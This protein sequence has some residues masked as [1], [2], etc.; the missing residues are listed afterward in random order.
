MNKYIGD[1]P[2]EVTDECSYNAIP[3][4]REATEKFEMAAHIPSQAGSREMDACVQ[5][6]FSFSLSMRVPS[7]TM[8]PLTIWG[9]VFY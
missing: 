2:T 3:H 7:H 1:F 4:G 6:I 5:L 8:V 9:G